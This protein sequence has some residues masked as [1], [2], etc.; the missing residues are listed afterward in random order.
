MFRAYISYALA[1]TFFLSMVTAALA[2]TGEYDNKCAMGLAGGKDI[3]TDCS[4]NTQIQGKTYCFGSQSALTQFMADPS[5][6]L[7]KAQ[8][9]YTTMFLSKAQEK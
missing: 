6:N 1:G 8:A 5:G 3:K 9:N 7:A 4:V 2:V